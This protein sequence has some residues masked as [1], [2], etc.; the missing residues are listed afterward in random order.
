M[1]YS[2]ILILL[3]S[4]ARHAVC[5]DIFVEASA[6]ASTGDYAPLWLSS[7]RQG[8]VSPYSSSAYERA[9]ISGVTSLT[10]HTT[11]SS[12]A[13]RLVYCADLQLSQNAQYTF[14]V[15]QL[16]GA[17][18]Y[19]RAT[20]TVGQRERSVD[21]RN[22]RLTS[23][24]LSQGINAQ[25]IPEV[26]LSLDYFSVPLTRQWWKICGRIG[27][28]RTTDGSWQETWLGAPETHERYTSDILYHEKA[29]YWKFGK[30]TSRLPLTFEIGLQM[31]TQFGGTTYNAVGRNHDDASVPIHHPEN[32][33]A[34]WHA[35]WPMGSEDVTDGMHPNSAGN[36]FGSYNMALTY[37]GGGWKARAYFERMFEDQSMLTVQY[38]IYDHLLGF[39]LELPANPFV[40]HVLIEHLN[41]KDQAGPVY[42][43]S[44]HNMPES[45][46]G[47]DN[48]YNHGLY[49]G[50]QNWGMGMGNPLLTAPIYNQPHV[51]QFRN[52]RLR[53]LH[54]GV[55]GNP[56]PDISW[57]LLATITR[58]WG[59]Y[60]QPF[61]DVLRQQYYLAEATWAPSFLRGWRA[62]LAIGL[63]HGAV[64][65]DSFGAQLTLRR[66]VTLGKN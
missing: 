42:H 15:H 66:T 2:F 52:N 41:T 56:T 47:I 59:T 1:R 13:I 25:P 31:M 9:G 45:Y 34:F 49:T 65:G 50:W 63:D 23:G 35:F 48:Y 21:L 44:T 17:L 36:T 6:T 12:H 27:F 54:I 8:L 39:D 43:D 61:D 26:L 20:L 24:G 58:N 14:F 10:R 55:D 33:N 18:T 3:L 4:C 16:Y 7:N 53:A 51:L 30:E 38:G 64:L 22:N 46:T 11:D 5:Q 32:L 28:G 19:R 60:R 62:T 40:S 37:H 29:M 57:R